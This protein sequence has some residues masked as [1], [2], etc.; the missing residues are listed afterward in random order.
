[1]LSI[2]RTQWSLSSARACRPTNG[3]AEAGVAAPGP[4][5]RPDPLEPWTSESSSALR[6]NY[7][8]TLNSTLT[9]RLWCRALNPLTSSWR[10]RSWTRITEALRTWMQETRF[11]WASDANVCWNN[12]DL[13]EMSNFNS[14]FI[15]HVRDHTTWSL[16]FTSLLL[17]SPRLTMVISL[18]SM[19]I[20]SLHTPSLLKT[21][22]THWICRWRWWCQR[23]DV[24]L[25]L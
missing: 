7:I 11:R 1:M 9:R 14:K 2:F 25:E 5:G 3:L 12:Y 13:L 24:T 18:V 20:S 4:P 6:A 15:Q 19:M 23:F 21:F 10:H 8:S 16:T 17:T 22:V